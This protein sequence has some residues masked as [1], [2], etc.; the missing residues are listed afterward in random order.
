MDGGREG[1]REGGGEGWREG[2]REGWREGG[3]G[4][5]EGEREGVKEGGG[6]GGMEGDDALCSCLTPYFR[7]VDAG[8]QEGTHSTGDHLLATVRS[9][10]MHICKHRGKREFKIKK[11]VIQVY[12]V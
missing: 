10:G 7:G 12:W 1:W 2:G 3:E 8:V 9:V 11:K 5:M 6:E 4:G